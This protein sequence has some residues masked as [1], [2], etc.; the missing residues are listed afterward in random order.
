MK[1]KNRIAFG[2]VFVLILLVSILYLITKVTPA[3][4][5][6]PEVEEKEKKETSTEI[7]SLNPNYSYKSRNTI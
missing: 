7:V 5:V 2:L 3:V 1:E 4:H 6:L